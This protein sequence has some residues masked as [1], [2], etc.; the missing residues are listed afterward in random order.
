VPE[1]R[2]DLENYKSQKDMIIKMLH[3]NT[4]QAATS[5]LYQEFPDLQQ[6]ARAVLTGR[7]H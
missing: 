6:K 7:P 3:Q 4:R 5:K 1:S 2:G